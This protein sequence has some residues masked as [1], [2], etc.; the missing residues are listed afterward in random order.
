MV[1]ARQ[2]ASFEQSQSPDMIPHHLQTVA[3]MNLATGKK[4]LFEVFDNARP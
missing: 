4:M 2:K 3:G 1:E